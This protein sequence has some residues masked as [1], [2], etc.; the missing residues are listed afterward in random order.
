MTKV[1]SEPNWLDRLRASPMGLAATAVA[2]V[3]VGAAATTE[4]ADKLM[5]LSGF[6]PNALQV[7]EEDA[8]GRFSRDLTRSAW[9]RLFWTRRVLLSAEAEF[10]EQEKNDIWASYMKAVDDWNSDL[11]VNIIQLQRYYGPEKR[12][13]LE[14]GIQLQ[15][16]RIHYCLEALRHPEGKVKCQLSA[17]RDLKAYEAAVDRLNA[18]LYCFASGLPEKNAPPGSC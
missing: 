15:F 17:N 18:D 9:R 13:Q 11:M 4:A 2:A 16:G 1:K 6:K 5:I 14:G 8:R 7:S 3:L 10:P 12:G